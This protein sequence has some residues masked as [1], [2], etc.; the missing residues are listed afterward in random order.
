VAGISR[1]MILLKR[2]SSL[3]AGTVGLDSQQA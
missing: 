3:M 2:V 1:R